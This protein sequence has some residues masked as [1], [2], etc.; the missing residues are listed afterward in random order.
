MALG[1]STGEQ[2]AQEIDD[3]LKSDGLDGTPSPW[4]EVK[5]FY[6]RR[7]L[8][9]NATWSRV[10]WVPI[11]GPIEVP[12]YT[13]GRGRAT[14]KNAQQL[15]SA[16]LQHDVF[17]HNDTFET[18]EALWKAMVASIQTCTSGSL[19]FEDFE[20]ITETQAHDFAVEG[21]MYRQ[22]VAISIPIHDTDRTTAEVLYQKHTGTFQGRL[23]DEDVCT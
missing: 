12:S 13:G 22:R 18:T 16:G 7:E 5:L 4:G 9:R 23:G 14:D 10:V 1:N 19:A 3:L 2:L 20:I 21:V 6:G 11:G 17:I 8:E 15:R